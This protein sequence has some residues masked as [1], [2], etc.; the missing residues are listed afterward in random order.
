ML[1]PAFAPTPVRR[2]AAAASGSEGG[3]VAGQRPSSPQC[4]EP[5]YFVMQDAKAGRRRKNIYNIPAVLKK[6]HIVR[7]RQSRTFVIK[8]YVEWR[9]GE[10]QRRRP[11]M[12]RCQRALPL[13]GMNS[14]ARS[15]MGALFQFS[16][17]CRV[18]R[19]HAMI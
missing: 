1:A 17:S 9:E 11:N 19:V 7:K 16:S 12:H 10:A 4:A 3:G 8:E 6:R 13:P 5:C 18:Y 2:H 15:G 14:G